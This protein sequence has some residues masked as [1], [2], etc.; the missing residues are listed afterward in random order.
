MIKGPPIVTASSAPILGLRVRKGMMV[1]MYGWPAALC[2]HGQVRHGVSP[3]R[4]AGVRY[5]LVSGTTCAGT[6]VQLCRIRRSGGQLVDEIG[7]ASGRAR[8]CQYV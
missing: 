4:E 1:S 7:R 2:G 3:F 8:G 6:L 5:R